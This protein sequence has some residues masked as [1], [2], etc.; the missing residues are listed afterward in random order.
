M[1][2]LSAE[3]KK[4]LAVLQKQLKLYLRQF[5]KLEKGSEAHRQH[6]AQGKKVQALYIQLS[7]MDLSLAEEAPELLPSPDQ[8]EPSNRKQQRKARRKKRKEQGKEAR[9]TR[10]ERRAEM[11]IERRKQRN[12]KSGVK[13]E[14][15]FRFEE[16][17]TLYQIL[18]VEKITT[19]FRS[20]LDEAESLLRKANNFIAYA[21][22]YASN[23]FLDEIE[24]VKGFIEKI[25]TFL[26]VARNISHQ[27]DVYG[28]LATEVVAATL[29]I[30]TTFA[31][32]SGD[33]IS[34]AHKV[35]AKAQA[36]VVSADL[37]DETLAFNIGKLQDYISVGQEKLLQL[38]SLVGVVLQD[39]DGNELPDWY[40][41]I[42]QQYEDLL[43]GQT[44]LIPGTDIDDQ[45]LLK[46]AALKS[47][48][49]SGLKLLM[50]KAQEHDI[51]EKIK[52]LES[53]LAVLNEFITAVTGF[54]QHVKEGDLAE[55]YT[56]LKDF[57]LF[58][59]SDRDLLEGTKIDD[60][61]KAKLLEYSNKA[62]TWL[63]NA[64]TGG[65]P[66]KEQEVKEILGLIDQLI[67]SSGSVPDHS[68]MFANDENQIK[69]PQVTDVSPTQMEAILDKY[70]ISKK[71]GSYEGILS[72]MKDNSEQIKNKV[73]VKYKA[74]LKRGAEASLAFKSA[75]DVFD[76]AVE[77]HQ[78]YFRASNEIG[79]KILEGLFSAI[80]L[81]VNSFAPGGGAIINS[82]G[83]ALTGDFKDLNDEIDKII[84]DDLQF[85][86]DLTKDILPAILPE[87]GSAMGDIQLNGK[88][89]INGLENLYINGLTARYQEVINLLSTVRGN[90]TVVGKNLRSV[91]NAETI[92]LDALKIVH[93]KV[94]IIEIKW[95]GLLDEIMNKY[96]NINYP[97]IKRNKAIHMASRYLCSSWLIKF[98]TKEIRIGNSM[99]A[100][101]D[102]YGILT[103]AKAEWEMSFWA[104]AGRSFFGFFGADP[105]DYQKE[106]VKLKKWASSEH[107][108]LKTV[109]AWSKAF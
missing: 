40:D 26:A 39:D 15:V 54:V 106:L 90:A 32:I 29:D 11:R 105:F 79:K 46:I 84:P 92:Q 9:A 25:E 43:G 66:D 13:E 91:E 94:I 31:Q 27:I 14:A 7:L 102:H 77:S 89:L 81:A 62:H 4:E 95:S 6:L 76:K 24:T 96:V 108:S 107:D 50:N 74:A 101:F 17:Q 36:F 97:P 73:D 87:L 67:L 80:G 30:P 98:P 35:L 93:K 56:K 82:I 104:T 47:S 57:K 52:N 69:I 99:I 53:W 10:R 109:K 85:F 8:T 5:T 75:K 20:F 37:S 44:D 78:S 88:E 45:I 60:I 38:E 103:E 55:I 1:P 64:L 49:E 16:I 61:I 28:K 71:A 42:A 70:G 18:N 48:I 100:L 86:A 51:Q 3:I 22:V 23:Q 65:D 41:K 68:K 83:K 58:L 21:E 59:E 63:M 2:E 19:N 34:N 72:D 12:D 33:V